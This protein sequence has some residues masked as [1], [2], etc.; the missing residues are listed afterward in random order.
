MNFT[1]ILDKGIIIAVTGYCLVFFA[2]LVLFYIFSLLSRAL[3]YNTKRKLSK[4]GKHIAEE[5]LV[6]SGE[7]T[8]A[9][10]LAIYLSRD[11]HDK[12]S[13]ILTIKSISKNY[14]PWSSKI[15]GMRNFRK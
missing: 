10:A 11:L 3:L 5:N 1:E 13:D 7:E 4:S 15:Y 9:I 6:I 8:A 14:S 12:E 2:L